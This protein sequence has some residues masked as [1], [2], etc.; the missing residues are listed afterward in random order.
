M[1][2]PGRPR[3]GWVKAVFRGRALV[4]VKVAVVPL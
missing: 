2:P 1:S 3:I 4:G